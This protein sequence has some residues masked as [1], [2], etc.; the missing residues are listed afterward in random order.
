MGLGEGLGV[1]KVKRKSPIRHRVSTHKRKGKIVQS[2]TRGRGSSHSKG[3]VVVKKVKQLPAPVPPVPP[4]HAGEKFE[5]VSATG[6]VFR[7]K[8]EEYDGHFHIRFV[9]GFT[10]PIESW[11]SEEKKLELDKYNLER[12]LYKLQV[13]YVDAYNTGDVDRAKSLK[14][15]IKKQEKRIKDLRM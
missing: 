15:L 7:G 13:M 10:S 12:G 4:Y 11:L 2:F 9:Q 5:H 8:I 1:M 6:D 14:G 3:K